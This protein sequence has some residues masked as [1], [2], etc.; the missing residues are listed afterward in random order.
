[1]KK[2]VLL[3]FLVISTIPAFSQ[4]DTI[5]KDRSLKG[6][7][8]KR[9][10]FYVLKKD[11]SVKHGTYIKYFKGTKRYFIYETGRYLYGKKEGLWRFFYDDF[12]P[13]QIESQGYYQNDR[14]NGPWEFFYF[15]KDDNINSDLNLVQQ[16]KVANKE[17]SISFEIK[18]ALKYTGIL[19]DNE[20]TGK[21]NYF[22]MNNNMILTINHTNDSVEFINPDKMPA[23]DSSG[24]YRPFF[25]G[26]KDYLNTMTHRKSIHGI[27]KI[28]T[29]VFRL[30]VNKNLANNKL[31]IVSNTSSNK[32]A[33]VIMN[34]LNTV[35]K[36]WVPQIRC[37]KVE[38][39]EIELIVTI[40]SEH[41]STNIVLRKDPYLEENTSGDFYHYLIDYK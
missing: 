14:P 18:G 13:D 5:F 39:S 30:I 29:I 9:E 3:F 16:N 23:K 37:G 21:W 10:Q 25:C 6:Q 22:D 41:Y 2:L 8:D 34:R 40:T 4:P 38:D 11:H 15:T 26:G 28:G 19:S 7:F 12:P 33:Q 27:D 31:S 36:D 17:Y 20:R 24:I 35:L 1:M 32:A